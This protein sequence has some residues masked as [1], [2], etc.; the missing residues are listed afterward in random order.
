MRDAA[1]GH[2][3]RRRRVGV[4]LL[5]LAGVCTIAAGTVWTARDAEA[6]GPVEGLDVSGHQNARGA[7]S[8]TKV[9]NAG[10]SFVFIKATEGQTYT[11]QYY[12]ANSSGAAAAGLLRG[13][14]HFARPDS[15]AG[16]AVGEAR[17]FI[18][19]AGTS[20]AGHLPP[21]L[22]L[23]DAGGLSTT[24][25]VA[26][27]KAFLREVERLTGRVPI[28]YTGPSFWQSKM[29]NSTQFKNYP[30]WLAQ[31]TTGQPT[32]PGGWPAYTFWQNTSSFTVPGITGNVDHNVFRGTL[33]QLRQLAAGSG[34]GATN[35]Y[36]ATEICGD[37]YQVIDQAA[38]GSAG[39]VYLLYDAAT[40]S[41]C[42]ATVKQS[43]VGAAS[44]TAAHLEVEGRPRS[45]DSGSYAYY[46]GPVRASAE[47]TC[48]KWGGSADG[49]AYDSPFEHCG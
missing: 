18:G 30:L 45:T 42:V 29:G 1:K 27:T 33:A 39:T 22:D 15:S 25:L 19:V 13:A 12:S 7:I 48:V 32:V 34:G 44:A 49:N 14:Y 21:V 28:I 38:L 37:G 23:E 24:A 11:D 4:W 2:P 36:T 20:P 40:G 26:W 47:N 41:N 3:V 9:K 10:Q 46:A 35:P 43:K 8:W 6:A 17:H 31:Y 5:A 16:D